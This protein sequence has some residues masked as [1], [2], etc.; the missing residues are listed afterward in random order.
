MAKRSQ[1]QLRYAWHPDWDVPVALYLVERRASLGPTVWVIARR[2]LDD[3]DEEDSPETSRKVL[4][5]V[6]EVIVYEVWDM[7]KLYVRD[8]TGPMSDAWL[9][10]HLKQ[11][12]P[13]ESPYTKT[14]L[15]AGCPAH[16]REP[17]DFS[18]W[19]SLGGGTS[20]PQKDAQ[21]VDQ[22]LP[23]APQTREQA[24]VSKSRT[25]K[26]IALDESSGD[27]PGVAQVLDAIHG[28]KS[29]LLGMDRRIGDLELSRSVREPVRAAPRD[30]RGR[31]VFFD[32]EDDED[33]GEVAAR[34]QLRSQGPH[35]G[36]KIETPVLGAS[37]RVTAHR[38]HL[39][40][41]HH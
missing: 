10:N 38:H 9:F 3:S 28:I 36:H 16:L 33:E 17:D 27:T 32:E 30:A 40:L 41:Q 14:S 39:P 24:V 12:P 1:G 19:A 34:P 18:P 8:Q 2:L 7:N 21:G 26:P 37:A 11:Q 25:P 6:E 23:E 35:R 29:D 15:L 31:T 20:T 5:G 22:A 4:P 13:E